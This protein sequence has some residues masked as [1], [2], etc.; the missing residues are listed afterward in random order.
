MEITDFAQLNLGWN[1]EPNV[2]FPKIA[3]SG[4]TLQLSFFGNP[5]ELPEVEDE[6]IIVLRFYNV[7][8]YVLGGTNDEGWYLGQCR[9]DRLAPRWGEFYEVK[10][11][12]RL[13]R[14]EDVWQIVTEP[15]PH[16]LKHYLFYFRDETFECDATS[17][18]RIQ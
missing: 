1:A 18:E 12:L 3:I 5:L 14:F 15:P 13:D 10:G 8:R 7:W 16:D 11:D 9:F 2:P 4:S 17:W 6:H